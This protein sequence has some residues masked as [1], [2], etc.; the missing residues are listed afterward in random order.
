MRVLVYTYV[1]SVLYQEPLLPKKF[2]F[3]RQRSFPGQLGRCLS[4]LKI[5]KRQI[6][7]QKSTTALWFGSEEYKPIG[8]KTKMLKNF[9]E[10]LDDAFKSMKLGEKCLV[11]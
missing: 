5:S 2:F 10:F 4:L 9:D 6:I 1:L 3:Y 8:F 7:L 11:Y